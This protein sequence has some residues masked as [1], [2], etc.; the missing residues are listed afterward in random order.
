MCNYLN[1]FFVHT[2]L[3]GTNSKSVMYVV[4]RQMWQTIR[5]SL[6]VDSCRFPK[7]RANQSFQYDAAT[8]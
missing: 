8:V 6:S 2:A 3:L 1:S 4:P 5:L 7:M